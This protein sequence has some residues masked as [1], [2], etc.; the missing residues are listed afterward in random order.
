MRR[1]ETI[2]I[3]YADLPEEDINSLL[4]RY[5]TIIT[6]R[7]GIVIKIDRWGKRKLAYEIN[8]QS[9]G[10]YVLMDFAGTSAIVTEI[11]RNL[12]ISDQILK[13]MTVKTQDT[14]NLQDLA[15]EMNPTV[16][17]EKVEPTAA[18]AQ[19]TDVIPESIELPSAEPEPVATGEGSAPGLESERKEEVE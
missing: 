19:E 13:Y 1:Y 10:F 3:T 17:E 8:K 18:P 11:E 5:S 12:R 4:A 9:R 14:V 7:Q 15:E 6:D 16:A 2:F